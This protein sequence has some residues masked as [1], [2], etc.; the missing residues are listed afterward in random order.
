M[1]AEH[2]PAGVSAAQRTN[3]RPLLRIQLPDRCLREGL[4]PVPKVRLMAALM[5]VK[6][7]FEDGVGYETGLR[8]SSVSSSSC[9]P[10]RATELP[11]RAALPKPH[12]GNEGQNSIAS[13][14]CVSSQ[15]KGVNFFVRP[16]GP[17]TA[18][19]AISAPATGLHQFVSHPGKDEGIG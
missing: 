12:F 6:L 8:S 10:C 7:R 14:A 19:Q 3:P 4:L 18:I 13:S 16:H 11:V 2:P 15:R 5:R 9:A 1:A 17:Q